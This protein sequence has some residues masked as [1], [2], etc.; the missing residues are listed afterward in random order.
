M[1]NNWLLK[2]A[3]GKYVPYGHGYSNLYLADIGNS[4]Y[5]QR[6]IS[7]MDS[8]IRAYRGVDGV[9]I[10][11]VVGNLISISDKFRDN[12]SYRQAMLAFMR[13]LAQR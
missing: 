12:A 5:Q 11:N 3:N 7:E 2:D 13:R 1:A 6:F 10:D 8:D 4:S 9:F